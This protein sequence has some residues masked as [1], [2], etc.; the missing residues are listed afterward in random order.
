MTWIASFDIGSSAVK[1]A[2]VSRDGA[3]HHART[4]AYP[5]GT[6]PAGEQDPRDWWDAFSAV[7]AGWWA[8]GVDP[9]AIQAIACAGQMQALV[10]LDEAGHAVL[11]A[12][13]HADAR[14]QVQAERLRAM[15]G[16]NAIE[17]ITRNPFNATSVLPKIEHLR[18]CEPAAWQ[19]T[20]SLLFGAKDVIARQLT[21]RSVVDP[22]TA[23]TT[24]MFHLVDARWQHAWFTALGLDAAIMPTILAPDAVVGG[25]TPQ[26]AAATGLTVGCPVLCGLGDAAATTLGAGVAD[27]AQCYAYLGTSGW[28][29]RVSA[30]FNP[31]G[32]PLFVLPYLDAARRI[33]IGP[34]SNAG[35]VHRWAL[36]LLDAS[37]GQSEAQRFEAFER[38]VRAAPADPRLL[39]L[40]YLSGERLPVVTAQP[41]GTFTG[42]SAS[43]TRAQMMRAALEGVSLSLRWALDTLDA[44]P[45]SQLVVVGGATRSDAWMQILA[46]VFDAELQVA[47]DADLLPCLGAAAVAAA[48]LGWC[49]RSEDFVRRRARAAERCFTPDA[50]AAASM[51]QKSVAFRG[52]QAAVAGL[53]DN[54]PEN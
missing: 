13:Q 14:A 27:A 23:A 43:T 36:G 49:E 17:L 44:Q 31:P 46:D 39:F 19:R 5:S 25:V 40:P 33:L 15:F 45:T 50:I 51:R 52:L 2:L 12:L 7:L 24:G 20:A 48:T 4:V 8:L 6:L 10:A 28:V 26:A 53:L 16:A 29:A 41:Q 32:T 34:V 11:P 37:P 38:A 30:G 21:G 42:L 35:G 54:G 9:R 18:A 22:T 47:P 1:G 3:L